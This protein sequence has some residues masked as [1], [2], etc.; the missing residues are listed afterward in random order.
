MAT[1]PPLEH[2]RQFGFDKYGPNACHYNSQSNKYYHY[3]KKHGHII[4]TFYRRNKS[5]IPITLFAHL[6]TNQI[7]TLVPAKSFR[8]PITLS[9]ANLENFTTQAL[10]RSRNALSSSALSIFLGKSSSWLLDS[11]CCNHMTL[12]SSFFSHIGY[13]HHTPTIYT[14]DGSIMLVFLRYFMCLNSVII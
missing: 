11:A 6:E 12:Y 9:M 2:P 3:C 13:T 7:P 8:S 1:T 14:V 5:V 4:D 10:I